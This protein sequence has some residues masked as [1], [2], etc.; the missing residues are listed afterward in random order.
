MY[1]QK[2]YQKLMAASKPKK[3]KQK[4]SL[5]PME[6]VFIAYFEDP[7]S[8]DMM[9]VILGAS[10]KKEAEDDAIF[11]YEDG[12]FELKTVESFKQWAK[13]RG[14]VSGEY[15]DLVEEGQWPTALGESFVMY[16]GS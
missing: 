8:D 12:Q 6:K 10:S 13:S 11:E 2:I 16:E 15:N 7:E 5:L 14:S 4:Q 3:E 9:A 1:P